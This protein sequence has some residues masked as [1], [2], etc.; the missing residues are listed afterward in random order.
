MSRDIL[1]GFNA[2]GIASATYDTVG[3]PPVR[4]ARGQRA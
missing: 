2:A 3:L 1:A 4:L